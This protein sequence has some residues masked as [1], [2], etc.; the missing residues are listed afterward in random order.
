MVYTSLGTID[1]TSQMIILFVFIFAVVF[2]VL[3]LS[4]I[5][6]RAVNTLI[7]FALAI[8]AI[9]YQPFVSMIWMYLPSM[10]WIFIILFFIA[11]IFKI[12]GIKLQSSVSLFD[13]VPSVVALLLLFSIGWYVIRYFPSNIPFIGNQENLMFLVGLI[14][15]LVLIYSII[16]YHTLS[17]MAALK[18]AQAKEKEKEK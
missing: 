5:F 14:F 2:G 4:K 9:S 12:F 15:I 11:F 6:S 17:E 8:F 13:I 18:E 16:K 7:S 10:V 1:P 3:N